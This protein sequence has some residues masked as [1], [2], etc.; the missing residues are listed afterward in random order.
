MQESVTYQL[1]L[2]EGLLQGKQEGLLQG[3]QEGLLQGK[4]EVAVNLLKSGMN[5]KQV[6][7]L[8][9]LTLFKV[10]ELNKTKE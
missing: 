5:T 6:A 9:G 10:E 1:I 2:E 8:T 7:E 4:Q 3:K